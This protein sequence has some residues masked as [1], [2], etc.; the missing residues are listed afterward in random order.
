[1]VASRQ[2]YVV[3]CPQRTLQINSGYPCD[4]GPSTIFNQHDLSRYGKL[5]ADFLKKAVALA[6]PRASVEQTATGCMSKNEQE[7]V[8]TEFPCCSRSSIIRVRNSC[9]LMPLTA[10]AGTRACGTM[11]GKKL[12]SCRPYLLVVSSS[13]K[14]ERNGTCK[15][16]W[17]LRL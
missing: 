4:L 3:E 12:L 14:F 1:M 13:W 7:A 8:I 6:E 5:R 16:R 15:K 17:K 2:G 9:L 11:V 10:S